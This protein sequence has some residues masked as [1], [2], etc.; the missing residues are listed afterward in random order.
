MRRIIVKNTQ[1][2]EP[3]LLEQ[4][5][6]EYRDF[7]EKNPKRTARVPMEIKVKAREVHAGGATVDQIAKSVGISRAAIDLWLKKIDVQEKR[8]DKRRTS[9]KKAREALEAVP[10]SQAGIPD[11]VANPQSSIE[12]DWVRIRIDGKEIEVAKKDFWSLVQSK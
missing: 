5:G 3:S 7:K 2:D 10:A 8:T 4:L 12:H 6:S 1:S 9:A 11:P